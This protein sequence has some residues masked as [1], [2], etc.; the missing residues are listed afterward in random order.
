MNI[1]EGMTHDE[2][3]R[4]DLARF[5]L[6]WLRD[7]SHNE[8][9]PQL[10]V[11]SLAAGESKITANGAL[12]ALTGEHTGRSPKDKFIVRDDRTA[13]TVWWNNSQPMSQN[14]F[15]LLKNDFLVHA[16]QKSVYVQDLE[17][18]ADPAFRLQTRVVTELAWHGLFIRHLLKPTTDAAFSAGL[19][20]I[21]FPSF[22]AD[23][24]RHG[25]K[26]RTVIAIDLS[27]GLVLIGGTAYAG[28]IKK[29]V[30]TYLNYTLPA[31]QVLPMHCSANVG[32]DGATAIFFGLSGTGKTTLSAD[33]H[34]VLVGDDEHGWGARGIFNIENGCYAKAINMS[35]VSEPDI[36]QA[37]TRFATVL[38]NV[39]LNES[40][41]T[42]DF[43]DNSLTENTRAAY[44]L[45]AMPNASLTRIA[46]PPGT[47]IMLC[48][49]AFGVMPPIAILDASQAMSMY[50]AG[51]TAKLA[52][53]ERG[54]KEPEATFSACFG[55]PFLPLHPNVYAKML[56]ERIA[57]HN[58]RCFLINTGWTGGGYGVGKRISLNVTRRL[59]AAAISGELD[60]A[61]TRT[62]PLHGFAV[63]LAVN[64]VDSLI[65]DPSKTWENRGAYDTAAKKLAG[66]FNIALAKFRNTEH[67]QFALAE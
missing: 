4:S 16:Q 27:N 60:N 5:G 53:T 12:V 20:I 35:P 33:R 24:S 26:S 10:F 21:N 48:A 22:K 7:I 47:I 55:A 3:I 15:E 38:E 6:R 56:G 1:A 37:S 62:D 45:T 51:Y 67:T 59:L 8:S 54:V 18:C 2:M 63:P 40:D 29:A 34:S 66:M 31:A 57:K 43:T 13:G 23:P 49:D 52:G 39:A 42:P 32:P 14:H 44:P 61:E 9:G 58:S 11:K 19:T 36:F 41:L 30:F 65:L 46:P 50:L 17:A 64:G 25:T 28:E